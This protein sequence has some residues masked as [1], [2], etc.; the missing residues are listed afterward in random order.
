MRKKDKEAFLKSITGTK[1]IQK[2]NNIKKSILKNENLNKENIKTKKI[3][4][5][6]LVEPQ[7]ITTTAIK[8]NENKIEITKINKKLKKGKIPPDQRIDFH[9]M[10]L[11]EAEELLCNTVVSCYNTNKRC[12]LFVTG[13]GVNKKETDYRIETKLY[14]GKIRNAFNSWIRKPEIEKYILSVEQAGMEYDADG[15][16]FVY[17][18]KKSRAF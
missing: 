15:A 3:V 2:K 16:F 6:N 12:I 17:L 13:K 9:G 7:I 10:S 11:I 1:P 14:Y 5:K 18:R 4:I 8:K